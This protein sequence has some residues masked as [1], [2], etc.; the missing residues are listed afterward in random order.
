MKIDD[1][2]WMWQGMTKKIAT[3]QDVA[4]LKPIEIARS[5]HRHALILLHGF[6]S[7]PAVF[8]LLLPKLTH[9]DGIFIPVLPGHAQSLQAFSKTHAQE[10]LASMQAYCQPILKQYEHVDLLGLSLGGLLACQLSQ[11]FTFHHL[12]LLAPALHLYLPLKPCLF[13]IRLLEGFGMRSIRNQAGNIHHPAHAELSY[14]RLPFKVITT[15]LQLIQTT[16][17][18]LPRCPTDVF[19]GEHDA[20]I[21]NAKVAKLFTLQPHMSLHWLKHSAHVLPLDA[22]YLQIAHVIEQHLMNT[23]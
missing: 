20:V 15:L 19:L 7:S 13:L 17:F 2:A 18:E 14:R 12:Y 9:Y 11:Q 22:D 1:F 10:W 8:R 5:P 3:H 16:S 21:N 4:L 6:A 23:P